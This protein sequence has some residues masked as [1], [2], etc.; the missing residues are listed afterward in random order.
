MRL[1]KLIKNMWFEF[2]W[3]RG[4]E[5][6][7]FQLTIYCKW[8]VTGATLFELQIAKFAIGFGLY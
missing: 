6:K 5:F 4:E 2:G 8:E 3:F 7:L 1:K